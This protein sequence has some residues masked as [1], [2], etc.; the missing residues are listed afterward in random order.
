MVEKAAVIIALVLFC[1]IGL[2]LAEPFMLGEP[3]DW[4]EMN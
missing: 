3:M 2:V 4:D 1:S